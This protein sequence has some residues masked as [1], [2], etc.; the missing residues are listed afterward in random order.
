[1]SNL[2]ISK[3]YIAGTDATDEEGVKHFLLI[4][5][6]KTL[7]KFVEGAVKEKSAHCTMHKAYH[8]NKGSSCYTDW[9]EQV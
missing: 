5:T 7:P 6:T 9:Q 8:S 1:M 4:N 3:V 2:E